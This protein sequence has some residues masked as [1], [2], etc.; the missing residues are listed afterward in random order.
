MNNFKQMIKIFIVALVVGITSASCQ[1]NYKDL[2]DG[3]YA[4]FQTTKGTMV[5]KLY[6]EKAPVTVANFV[7]LAEGTHPSLADSLKGKPFYDG[8]TFHRVMDKF[9]IQGGDPTATG[10]GSAGYKFHSEFDQE[11][12]HDKAGILSMANS[13][14]LTTNGSQFFITEVPLKRLDA[15]LADGTLKNCNAPRTSCHPVFGELVKGLEV[16]DSISNVAVS[17]ERSSANKPLEDVVINKL[18]IIRKGSAAKAFDAPAVFTEQEPLLPQRIEEIKKKQEE[19]AKEKAKIAADSFKKANADLKGEVYE[20]PTGM[21]MITTK[22]GNGVKPKPSDNVYI[23]CAGYF[24]DGTLF[25]TTWKDVAKANGT[26]DE[27]ADENGFYKPFDR[28]YNTSAGLI[29]GFREAFLRMKIGDKA[30]VFIP[31]FLGYGA[32]ANGPIPANSNLIFDI[33]LMSI[34]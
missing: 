15:F 4:E 25:Y 10:M 1:D 5:A 26:Y 3:L 19:I 2:E 27:K 30:K 23:N 18:T 33:E 13:G 7:G 20:S 8:I 21:V 29:P 14:G 24:E 9:M 22:E 31:S 12:S 11:L 32:A 16:Q 6:F 28:K 34:K 17:K